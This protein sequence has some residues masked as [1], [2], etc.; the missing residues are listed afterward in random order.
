M[1]DDFTRVYSKEGPV[2]SSYDKSNFVLGYYCRPKENMAGGM[3]PN[4]QF[5]EYKKE[6]NSSCKSF[7]ILV[8]S[9]FDFV[10]KIRSIFRRQ[11]GQKIG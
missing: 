11:L 2:E 9:K 6:E 8:Q 7:H 10:N 3:P 4:C 1:V 5:A